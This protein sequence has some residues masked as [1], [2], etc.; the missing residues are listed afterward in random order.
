MCRLPPYHRTAWPH[1]SLPAHHYHP[2]PHA[3]GQQ[4]TAATA[5]AATAGGTAAAE[6]PQDCLL[7]RPA[8]KATSY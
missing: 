4:P 5:A 7:C 1:G 2:E 8:W 6:W 3:L